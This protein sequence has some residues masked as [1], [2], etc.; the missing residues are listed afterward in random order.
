MLNEAGVAIHHWRTRPD[1]TPMS[2]NP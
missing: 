1:A 2:K